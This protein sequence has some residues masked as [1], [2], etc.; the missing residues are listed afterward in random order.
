MKKKRFRS[1]YNF[2]MFVEKQR[3]RD[4]SRGNMAWSVR[5]PVKIQRYME[6]ERTKIFRVFVEKQRARSRGFLG[7]FKRTKS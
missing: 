5:M 1:E 3:A 2:M 6:T 4:R 7:P